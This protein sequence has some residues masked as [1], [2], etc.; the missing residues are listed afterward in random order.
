MKK[1]CAG[2]AL[3]LQH[4]GN[5][6]SCA[7]DSTQHE[8]CDW[9]HYHRGI[10]QLV[11]TYEFPETLRGGGPDQLKSKVQDQSKFAWGRGGQTNSNQKCQDMSKFAWEGGRGW[12]R[13]TQTQSAKICPNLHFRGGVVVVQTNIPEILWGGTQ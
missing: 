2:P 10:Q 6:T 13:P 8:L 4:V 12:S 9:T 3:R 11:S 1:F 7:P 5:A